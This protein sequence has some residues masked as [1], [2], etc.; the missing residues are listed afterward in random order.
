[1]E[2]RSTIIADVTQASSLD[3]A[4]WGCTEPADYVGCTQEHSYA[5]WAGHYKVQQMQAAHIT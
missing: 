5:R 1:M 4:G 2:R 3:C